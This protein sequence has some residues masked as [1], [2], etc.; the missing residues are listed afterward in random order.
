MHKFLGF[1]HIKGGRK[2]GRTSPPPKKNELRRFAA[3]LV[4]VRFSKVRGGETYTVLG[5]AV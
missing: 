5:E 4:S 1:V 2:R 3:L